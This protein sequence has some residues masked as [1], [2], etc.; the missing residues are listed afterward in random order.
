MLYPK[1]TALIHGLVTKQVVPG[2]SYAYLHQGQLQTGVFGLAQLKPTKEKLRPGMYYDL[3]SLTKVIGTTTVILKLIA[4]GQLGV[5]DAVT[6]Y[7]PAFKDQRVTIRH[8]LTHTSAISGYIKNR[9]ELSPAALLAALHQLKV[10]SDLGKK[11]VYTDIGLI[12]LGEIIESFY[13][14][15]VQR[16]IEKEVLARLGL[17]QSTFNPP[18]S[19]A[20]PTEL[21]AK[22]GLIRGQVHDPK[23][24]TLKEHCG[25]AGLFM[26]LHD[27]VKFS[28]WLLQP[29][30]MPGPLDS[31]MVSALFKDWTPSGHDGRS[32]GWDLRYTWQNQA[33]LYHT[34]Y[35]G[36]MLLIDQANQD[37]LILLTNRVHPAGNNQAFLAQRELLLGQ[38]LREKYFYEKDG[39]K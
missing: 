8:L 26:T 37:A 29:D 12:F 21:T 9:D 31:K 11:V 32:L 27:M 1:T 13:Q 34:G 16:V 5:D 33:C 7:L 39:S 17:S 10:G 24:Y 36:T 4:S 6:K 3:A 14:Q 30:S 19:L 2:V 38:Y 35:T 18:L 22:R 25:S 20:V 28:Q 23:A 15:P